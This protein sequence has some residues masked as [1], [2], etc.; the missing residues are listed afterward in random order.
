[1][2]CDTAIMLW[3]AVYRKLIQAKMG[4]QGLG[5]EGP[6]HYQKRTNQ[7]SALRIRSNGETVTKRVKAFEA[8]IRTTHDHKKIMTTLHVPKHWLKMLMYYSL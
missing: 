8:E 1:M 6:F 4:Q 7:K 3:L 2:K 5:K